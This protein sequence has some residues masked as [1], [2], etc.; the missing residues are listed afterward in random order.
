MG[1]L[2]TRGDRT[3]LRYKAFSGEW[4]GAPSGYFVG[5]EREA[6][7]LLKKTEARI[8]ARIAA[9]ETEES[10]P[11]TVERYA[12]KW[13]AKRT[14]HTVKDDEGRLKLHALPLLQNLK[15]DEVRPRHIRELVRSLS[16][17]GKLAPRS[18][19]NV[20]GVLHT[21]FHD[22][23]VEELIDANPCVLKREDLPRKV[24]KNPA[25]RPTAI[26]AREE[27][28]KLISDERIPEDRRVIYALLA[29][30]GPRFGEAAALTWSLYDATLEP[31]GKLIVAASYSV[32]KKAVKAVKTERPRE[33]P[34][35][36]TLAKILAAWKL[37]GWQR[38]IGRSPGPDDLIVPSRLGQHR[39]VN[40]ALKRFHEDCERVGL[41]T[42]RLHDLRRSF[43]TLARTDGARKDVLEVV[44][45]GSRGDIVDVYSSLP[46]SLLCE[47]VA[48]LRLKVLAG[49]VIALPAVMSA[50]SASHEPSKPLILQ[51]VKSEFATSL[52]TSTP[53]PVDTETEKPGTVTVPGFRRVA[54]WT[55]L[56][57]AASG[58]TGRRYNRLNYHPKFSSSSVGATGFE[59]VT[60]GL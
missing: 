54:G 60:P 21:M 57:P 52:A 25:W 48:K 4:T 9:G 36:P 22:A 29:L 38:L 40:H 12:E 42:R 49:E 45:H 32:K 50:G 18:V 6:T 19:R 33:V 44:T 24:D 10:G 35:H 41:R 3:W 7:K 15:M 51:A 47:E 26:F 30:G 55:G 28:E 23:Q 20:Y 8:Q 56:E 39:S 17:G 1:S 58:V 11:I 14:T 43:I 37:G 13:L 5:Q 46:W 53:E 34:V 27:I 59:P 16:D 31:L 2:Y